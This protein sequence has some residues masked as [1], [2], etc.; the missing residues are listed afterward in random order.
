MPPKKYL[1]IEESAKEPTETTA[2][3]ENTATDP[4]SATVQTIADLHARSEGRVSPHQRRIERITAFLG[5]PIAIFLSAV[6]M[7]L[8]ITANLILKYRLGHTFDEPPFYW[9][10]G[11]ISATALFTTLTVLATQNRQGRINERR[12]QLDL[13]IS[14]LVEHKVAKLIALVEELRHDLPN[15]QD[16]DDPEARTMMKAA[17]PHQVIKE[18]NRVLEE[19]IQ[20][21]DD[22]ADQDEKD[23][24]RDAEVESGEKAVARA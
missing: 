3:K 5:R 1:S 10:Q 11:V 13:Q 2:E 24:A 14:L 21:A 15:V 6:F 20:R 19:S 4:V 9:L 23:A 16:H 17:D 7:G 8:W 22:L 12:E 18:L